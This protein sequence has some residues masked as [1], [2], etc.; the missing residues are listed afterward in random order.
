MSPTVTLTPPTKAIRAESDSYRIQLPAS[1]SE[2]NRML[3]IRAL[4]QGSIEVQNLSEAHD[5][6]TMIQLLADNPETLDVGHAGTAMRFLTA[7]QAFR[8]EDK[9][10]TGSER[11]QQR[12]ISSRI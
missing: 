6:Q 4:S 12:P 9:V 7:F 5:T 10:L 1:K 3:V 11:M 2:S 8:T